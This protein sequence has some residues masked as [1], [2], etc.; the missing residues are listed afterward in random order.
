[1][2]PVGKIVLVFLPCPSHTLS[3]Q[4]SITELPVRQFS[5]QLISPHKPNIFEGRTDNILM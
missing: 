5:T 4:Q 2:R 1:M 3:S